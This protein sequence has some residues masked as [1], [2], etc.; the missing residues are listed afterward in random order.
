M[1]LI[2]IKIEKDPSDGR[3]RIEIMSSR[4]KLLG[5]ET[6]L[7]GKEFVSI[8]SENCRTCESYDKKVGCLKKSELIQKWTK[9]N[10]K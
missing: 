3:E 1:L 9:E 10:K 4:I 7:S 6:S 5:N 8:C 2:K